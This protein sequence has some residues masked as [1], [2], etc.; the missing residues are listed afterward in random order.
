MIMVHIHHRRGIKGLAAAAATSAAMVM[1]VVMA[2]V[3]AFVEI[4]AMRFVVR[5]QY[6]LI[7]LYLAA[8]LAMATRLAM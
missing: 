8:F 1:T 3:V 7:V 5:H 4:C 2:A 6:F